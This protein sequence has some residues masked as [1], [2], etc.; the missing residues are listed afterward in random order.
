MRTT[1]IVAAYLLCALAADTPP[2]AAPPPSYDKEIDPMMRK[3]C[4]T[5]HGKRMPQASVSVITYEGMMKSK[6]GKALIIPG[7]PDKSILLRT[8]EGHDPVMPPERATLQP[9]KA[10]VSKV[11]AWI[12]AGAKDDTPD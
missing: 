7:Q 11:R 2:P 3:Y 8:M 10:E 9:T 5:C 6:K 4:G 12:L 1:L